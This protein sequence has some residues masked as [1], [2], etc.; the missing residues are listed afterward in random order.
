MVV[1]TDFA[2]EFRSCFP[3]GSPFWIDSAMLRRSDLHFAALQN[4]GFAEDFLTRLSPAGRIPFRVA[5][6]RWQRNARSITGL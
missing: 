5:I 2:T 6:C 3:S 1:A 4:R